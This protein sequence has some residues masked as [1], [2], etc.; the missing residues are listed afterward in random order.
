MA[1]TLIYASATDGGIAYYHPTTY[2]NARQGTGGSGALEGNAAA[3]WSFGQR[4]ANPGYEVY[5]G[6]T[7]F[8]YS[9]PSGAGNDYAVSGF[10]QFTAMQAE[11]GTVRYMDSYGFNWGG[12]ALTTSDFCPST[13]LATATVYGRV[14]NSQAWGTGRAKCSTDELRALG[15]TSGTFRFVHASNRTRFALAPAGNEYNKVYSAD[16]SGTVNDPLL[17]LGTIR[18]NTLTYVHAASVNLSDGSLAFI[19]SNGAAVPSLTLKY[20]TTAGVVGTIAALTTGDSGGLGFETGRPSQQ[21]VAL[22]RDASDNLYVIARRDEGAGTDNNIVAKAYEKGA[23]FSWTGKGALSASAPAYTEGGGINQCVGAWHATGGAGHIMLLGGHIGWTGRVGTMFYM[24]LSCAPLLAGSGSFVTASGA[25]PSFLISASADYVDYPNETGSH[26]DVMADPAVPTRGFAVCT[27]VDD[28]ANLGTYTLSAAGTLASSAQTDHG[29]TCYVPHDPQGKTR[30]LV[31]PDSRVIYSNGSDVRARSAA[32]T[33]LGSAYLDT[34]GITNFPTQAVLNASGAWDMM[35][36]PA[37]QRVW[38]YYLD[39]VDSRILR[40]TSFSTQNYTGLGNSVVVSSTVGAVGTTNLG[41]RLARGKLD[42]R[43]VMV[44][45]ANNA[46]GVLST[47]YVDDTGLNTPPTAPL[48]GA[49]STFDATQPKVLTWQ[50]RDSNPADTQSAYEVEIIRTSDSVSM[51]DTGQVVS[52]AQQHTIP[53]AT[54]ANSVAYQWRVRTWDPA[55]QAGTWSAF[56]DFTT[57][58]GGSV[59]ITDPAA[60]N[61]GNQYTADYLVAW[62]ASGTVQASYRVQVIRTADGAIVSDTGYITS[63]ATSHLVQNLQSTT[64]YRIQV[65]VR[66]AALA[67]SN[68]GTRLITPSY[69]TPEVPILSLTQG[70]TYVEVSVDNPAPTGDRPDVSLN[71]LYRRRVGSAAWDYLAEIAPNGSWRDYSAG[72]LVPYE[73]YVE[74]VV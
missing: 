46:A 54:L 53:A 22:V 32:G 65:T 64:E 25:D 49:V 2:A 50:H 18:R 26:L 27:D 72:A 8:P 13:T 14:L 12:G 6:F 21:K 48:L 20:R 7:E 38:I 39:T 55:G 51:L 71:R 41:I 3:Y 29:S 67:V 23:G 35:Y 19:E 58:G 16:A 74:A 63:V 56:T 9:N 24:V 43:R 11:G 33:V 44:S 45:V 15:A 17:L 37:S 69:S 66:N 73:Y 36:D 68:P 30:V 4:F 10:L 62:S 1:V 5:E 59:T 34:L 60:D 57:S 52:A 70:P 31:L 61:P 42:E 28:Y 47:V 40:R